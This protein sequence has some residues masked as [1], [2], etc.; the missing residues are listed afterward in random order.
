MPRHQATFCPNSTN[1]G[2]DVWRSKSVLCHTV[3]TKSQTMQAT[4]RKKMQRQKRVVAM[5]LICHRTCIFRLQSL[6]L[7]AG[8][9]YLFLLRMM[10]CSPSYLLVGP[11]RAPMPT[12]ITRHFQRKI[13]RCAG[14]NAHVSWLCS[15]SVPLLTAH[16]EPRSL[17]PGA[18]EAIEGL[19]FRAQPPAD[20]RQP[21]RIW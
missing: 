2:H 21:P 16:T 20:R 14:Q 7:A 10:A 4:Q 13:G 11:G 17:A 19:Y 12:Q 18:A 3:N 6:R 15:L 9:F 5:S 8:F 1:S